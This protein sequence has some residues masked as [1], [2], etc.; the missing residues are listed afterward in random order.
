MKMEELRAE[1]Q[2]ISD[3]TGTI[4]R[5][6]GASVASSHQQIS[7]TVVTE[8]VRW[9]EE[10]ISRCTLF[11]SQVTFDPAIN[12]TS[13]LKGKRIKCANVFAFIS[14]SVLFSFCKISL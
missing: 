11:S 9:N 4:G 8:F 12:F 3:S 5:S 2:Q 10:A 6:K 7:V 1:N 13:Y 14:I